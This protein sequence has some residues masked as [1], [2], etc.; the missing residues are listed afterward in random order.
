MET[1]STWYQYG[2]QALG[3][4]RASFEKVLG[5]TGAS[6]GRPTGSIS[7]IDYEKGAHYTAVCPHSWS[8]RYRLLTETLVSSSYIIRTSMFQFSA[9]AAVVSYRPQATSKCKLYPNTA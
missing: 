9:V 4:D 7:M 3:R 1:Q 8:L 2:L 6:I 5:D